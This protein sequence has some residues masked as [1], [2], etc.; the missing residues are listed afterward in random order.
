MWFNHKSQPAFWQQICIIWRSF[1]M[2]TLRYI[3]SK[4]EVMQNQVLCL[5]E[6]SVPLY[7]L[8][9]TLSLFI[10]FANLWKICFACH[11]L[12]IL[13]LVF[14]NFWAFNSYANF[15]PHISNCW[16]KCFLFS[17][18]FGLQLVFW[19]IREETSWEI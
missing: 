4:V 9:F 3:E 13:L 1:W 10:T 15:F 16:V 11:N 14:F 19:K 18:S 8:I 6:D 5:M 2:F 12:H 7:L 17:N